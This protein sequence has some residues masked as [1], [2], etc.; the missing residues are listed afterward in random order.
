MAL[1]KLPQVYWCLCPNAN[2]YIENTLPDI[3]M[4]MEENAAICIGTD[5]LSSNHQLCVLSELAS[6]R[7]HYPGIDWETLLAWGT[8]NGACALQMQGIVGSIEPGKNPGIVQL[9]G[10]YQH[11]AKPAVTRIV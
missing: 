7:Q 10:L 4:L 8:Y 1:A 9:Q 6:I 3:E 5:S 11:G 2:L